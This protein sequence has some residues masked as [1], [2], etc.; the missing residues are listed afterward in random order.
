MSRS[1]KIEWIALQ[2]TRRWEGL[3]EATTIGDSKGERT[4][5]RRSEKASSPLLS[6]ETDM[7]EAS[8]RRG[9]GGAPGAGG[10]D[11]IEAPAAWITLDEAVKEAVARKVELTAASEYAFR[12]SGK[13]PM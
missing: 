6:P 11:A 12:C 4:G 13:A 1:S 2:T 3:S 10:D 8:L 5:G 7:E 9:T